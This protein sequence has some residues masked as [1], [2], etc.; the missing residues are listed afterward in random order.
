MYIR[1]IIFLGQFCKSVSF[2]KL[3]YAQTDSI[4][5]LTTHI[6]SKGHS[7]FMTSVER[8]TKD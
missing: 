3:C 2:L 4:C 1:D 7:V 6:G 8:G 5:R